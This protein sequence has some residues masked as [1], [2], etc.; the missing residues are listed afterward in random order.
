MR[1][2]NRNADNERAFE[3]KGMPSILTGLGNREVTP[4]ALHHMCRSVE[5]HQAYGTEY[6]KI[7][8]R[9]KSRSS[10]IVSGV[11]AQTGMETAEDCRE[12]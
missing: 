6:G 5:Y 11:M 2:E 8:R 1:N 7:W 12:S 9:R 3:R 10:A 4:D